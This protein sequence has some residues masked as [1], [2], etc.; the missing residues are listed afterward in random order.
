MSL[1]RRRLLRQQESTLLYEKEVEYLQTDGNQYFSLP[2]KAS[3]ATDAFEITFR[4]TSDVA[5]MRLCYG[6]G[7]AFHLY[8][9]GNKRLAYSRNESWVA[10]SSSNACAIG[11]VKHTCK[12]DYLNK[13]LT[14]DFFTTTWTTTSTKEITNNLYIVR[15]FTNSSG[16]TYQFQGL[17]YSV[18]FWRSGTLLYD[19][20]PVRKNGVGYFFDKINETLYANEGTGNW[21]IG[22]DKLNNINYYTV[23]DYLENTSTAATAPYIDTGV[24]SNAG[25]IQMGLTAK[26]NTVSST[27][28]QLFGVNTNPWFGCDNGEYKS[29][30]GATYPDIDPPSTSVYTTFTM[31]SYTPATSGANVGPITLFRT[32]YVSDRKQTNGTYAYVASCKL[33]S[34]QIIVNGTTVRNFVPVLH[35]SGKYGMFDLIENKFYMSANSGNFTGGFDA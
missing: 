4:A 12:L 5:Q 9:N 18:K 7:S 2:I 28:R 13:S 26:W 33:K 21:T 14:Y 32:Y 22:I 17:V 3:E 25:V 30:S 6:G 29:T 8:G 20:V 1:F 11:T 16:V 19:L 35:P 34:F 10:M 23:L 24:G 15:P 31:N 27:R